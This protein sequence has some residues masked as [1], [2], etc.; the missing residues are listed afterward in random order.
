M[1][2]TIL[3]F[4]YPTDTPKI[5]KVIGVGGGG[6]NAVTHMYKEGI[7]DVTFVLCN[8][9]NQALN[10]SDVPVKV[11]LGRNITQGLGAGNKPERAMMAAEESMEDI[12]KMLSDGTKMV[13]ITAGMGGGTGTG[14][15]PVIA[16][17]AKD[18]GILTVGIVT[19]PFVFEGERKIIQALNG[20]EEISKNVDALLVINNERL[21]EIYSDLTM[22]NAFG[23]AD[24]T[25][26]IAAKSIAEIITLPGIINL[27]FAD[28]N[29]T[30][31]DGGV[32]LMSNGFG[33]GEGRVRQAIEDALNS[34]LLNNN[35]VFNAKKIL[36]NVSFG[37]E[38]ELRMEEMND[39]HDFMSRFGRDIE[40]IWGTAIDN[41]LGTKVKMTILATGFG[42][43]DIPDI[44]EKRQIE[45][46]RMTEEEL[47]LEEERLNKER[48]EKDLIDKYY[49]ASGQRMRR[50]A[51][52]AKAVVLN[53]DELDDDALIALIEDNPTYNRDPKVIA[54]ARSK[55][56]GDEIPVSSSATTTP[57]A[58]RSEGKKPDTGG[59]Q[60]ISFR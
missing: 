4:N 11:P 20:V 43:E 39:V 8:T 33:E 5:I 56:M 40:V 50:V 27:D 41:T 28:V 24:D 23:K 29:T 57:S 55:V 21:R 46:G 12:R 60:V 2:D 16:R 48:A 44:G 1:D 31:K 42:M 47:R 25:L 35:D 18:M 17:F 30:M 13:F 58:P 59:K 10:R 3:S 54:R 7:H 37:E 38:A 36:F 45:Q 51:A 52:R 32:A 15:A 26:T 34:P 19:I 14:A 49:G 22:T 6:G 9:D 53:Q